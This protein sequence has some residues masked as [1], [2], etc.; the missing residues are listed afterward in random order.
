[1]NAVHPDWI[2]PQWAAP[3]RV[4]ALV[5]T[6]A[7]GL[8]E[9]AFAGLNLGTHV[10]D[11]PLRVR[12]NRERLGAALPS[13]P[14]WL[15]QVHGVG[16]VDADHAGVGTEGDASL[17]RQS[18]VVCAVLIADCL[19]VLFA[20]AAGSVVAAAHA[21]WRGLANG[22]L[23]RTL[24]AMAVPPQT[25]CAWLGPA[26]GQAA[27]EVGEEV[28]AAFI[29]QDA[30]AH[31][32]FVPGAIQGKWHADLWLLARQRLE[33][34]GVTRVAGGGLCTYSDA[35]RFYSY[36]RDGSCGRFASMVWLHDDGRQ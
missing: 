13:Q 24:E 23:E 28:R 34:A 36:R 1:M 4:G 17:A 7:G 14:V 22:V 18:G 12:R 10:G 30:A 35:E 11:D 3:A 15:E 5:T 29:A 25:V 26:I 32:A 16:V 6:R 33:R 20:D 19:P 2:V 8:S 21:G 31:A 9:G 27:F